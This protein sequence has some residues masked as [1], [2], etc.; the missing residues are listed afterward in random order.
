M[1]D[2]LECKAPNIPPH[3]GFEQLVDHGDKV[4]VP[5]EMCAFLEQ[6]IRLYMDIAEMGEMDAIRVAGGVAMKGRGNAICARLGT[7]NSSYSP[8]QRHVL[9]MTVRSLV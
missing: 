8:N 4:H 5:I 7:V 9:H 3:L 2:G 6:A 1:S